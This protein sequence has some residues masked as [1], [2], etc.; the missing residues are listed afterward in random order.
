M[1]S[2]Q[3]GK[4]QAWARKLIAETVDCLAVAIANL[5]VIFDPELIVLGGGVTRS[6]RP[7]D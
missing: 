4:G 3:R 6:A 5:T 1:F 7:A 2:T